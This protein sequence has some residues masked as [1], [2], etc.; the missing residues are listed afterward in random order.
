LVPAIGGWGSPSLFLNVTKK[1]EKN[2]RKVRKVD[3]AVSQ[4][5]I[6]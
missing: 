2:N 5:S 1:I 3:Q 4:T 6:F